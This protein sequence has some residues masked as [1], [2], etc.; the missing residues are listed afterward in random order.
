[1]AK[2]KK[3]RAEVFLN[4]PYDKKFERLFLT[5]IAGISAYGMVP[6][7]TLEITDSS[8]RLEKILKL[9]RSCEY[10]VHDLSRVELDRA[11]PRTPRFNMPFE[12]GLCVADANRREGQKQNWFVFEA[13]ANRVDKSLS[14][15]RGTDPRIHGAT[16][17]GVLSGLCNAFRRPGRQPTV[18]Q[19]MQIYK[20]LRRNQADILKEAGSNTLY[21]RRVFA[22]VCVVASSEADRIVE[23]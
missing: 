20:G 1:V 16:V 10:S 2:S 8:R 4:I 11:K 21:S 13:V 9:E 6:R 18:P 15:L 23:D 3:S 7:A 17:R 22:G 12:L 5:Y 14:D 19:M